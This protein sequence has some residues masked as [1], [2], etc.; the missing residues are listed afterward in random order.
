MNARL[1]LSF[2]CYAA[3]IPVANWMISHVGEQAFPGGP[4]VIPVG[5]GYSAPSGVLLIGLA[6]AARDAVQRMAGK[7]LALCAIAVGVLLSWLVNPALAW[8]S[9]AAFAV[10]EL[11]DFAVYSPL[12]KR[13]LPLAVA[14][15]GVIGGVLDSLIFLQLAFHSTDYWQGQ[16]IGK[17]LVAITAGLA[18]AGYR[19]ATTRTRA[20]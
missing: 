18:V 20:R 5:F 6:L 14:L 1:A 19:C 15:S 17:S 10:G 2:G 11:A 7:R 9:A 12:Q 13:A 8:A 4:H 3:T 16:V